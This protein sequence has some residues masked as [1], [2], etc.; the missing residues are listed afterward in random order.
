MHIFTRQIGQSLAIGG[1]ISVTVV[2][3]RGAQVRLGIHAAPDVPILREEIVAKYAAKA[4]G[5]SGTSE[6]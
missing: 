6:L 4:R 3:I 1:S 2:A 5:S